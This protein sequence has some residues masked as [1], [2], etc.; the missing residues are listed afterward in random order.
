LRVALGEIVDTITKEARE[1]G[2]DLV[3]LGRGAI[4][5]TLGRLRTHAH[6]IIQRSPCP[7]LSV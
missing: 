1:Q 7:V 3:V 6:G 2:A 4:H 5:E